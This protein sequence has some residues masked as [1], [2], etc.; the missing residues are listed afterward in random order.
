MFLRFLHTHYKSLLN[1]FYMVLILG[2][3]FFALLYAFHVLAPIIIGIVIF[4][5]V[6]PLAVTL[7]RKKMNKMW[8]T[9]I[10][11]TVFVT[12]L[13]LTI[14]T[15]SVLGVAKTI[16]FAQTLPQYS[17]D[18][19]KWVN[20]T[21]KV[22]KDKLDLVPQATVDKMK[23]QAGEFVKKSATMISEFLLK[24]I[25]TIGILSKF[26][27]NLILGFIFAFLLSVNKERLERWYYVTMPLPVKKTCTFISKHVVKGLMAYFKAQLKL[28]SITFVV[29]YIAL[30][31]F[32]VKHAFV[33]SLIA[34]FFDVLPLL[35]ISTLFIPWI[36]YLFIVGDTQ[37]AICLTVLWLIVVV[38]RH[39]L[40]PKI[41]GESIGVNAFEMFTTM[42]ICIGVFGFVGLFVSPIII[43]VLKALVNEGYLSEWMKVNPSK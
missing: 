12:I 29:V 20:D 24:L 40:E 14:G 5:C 26:L 28:I 23:E 7:N 21:T 17:D 8:A 11:M 30:L 27:L 34:G 10:S 43:L 37:L 33:I 13:T 16:D 2:S 3:A 15:L 41:T 1:L 32:G 39:I 36:G 6:E 31:I 22:T 35:G 4:A 25:S 42:L 9:G 38:T 19:N 18:V